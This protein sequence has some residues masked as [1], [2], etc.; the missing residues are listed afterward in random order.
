MEQQIQDLINTGNLVN[1]ELAF[2]LAGSL[3][4]AIPEIDEW[5]KLIN[6]LYISAKQMEIKAGMAYL[7]SLKE[8]T[9]TL[10]HAAAEAFD[11]LPSVTRHLKQAEDLTIYT[12]L[13]ALPDWLGEMSGLCRIIFMNK[14]GLRS[15]PDSI[16]QL[17]HL[18]YLNCSQQALT[19]FPPQLLLMPWLKRLTIGRNQFAQL[20]DNMGD[21]QALNSLDIGGNPFEEFPVQ[22]ADLPALKRIDFRYSTASGFLKKFPPKVASILQKQITALSLTFCD[23]ETLPDWVTG[24]TALEDF[25]IHGNNLKMLPAWLASFPNLKYLRASRNYLTDIHHVTAFQNL[26]WLQLSRNRLTILPEDISNLSCLESLWID[27]NQLKKLPESLFQMQNLKYLSL[28]NNLF[29]TGYIEYV[30]KRMPHC[31]IDSKF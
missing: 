28:G 15:L 13:L 29:P 26:Q 8:I 6:R 9:I 16:V 22:I 7:F 10:R 4:I 30:T 3:G 14:G 20:P 31:K 2:Q 18:E 5:K 21:M 1:I 17:K 23:W 19:V 12:N 24:F 11:A 27:N 25:A